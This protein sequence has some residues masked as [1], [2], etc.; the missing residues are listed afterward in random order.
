MGEG[1]KY[2]LGVGTG[3]WGLPK[4]GPNGR[5]P[6][7]ALGE[8]AVAFFRVSALQG[9]GIV[10]GEEAGLGGGVGCLSLFYLLPAQP[11]HPAKCSAAIQLSRASGPRETPGLHKKLMGW[12]RGR[13]ALPPPR[14]PLSPGI[15]R[16][17]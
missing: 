14:F 11:T 8:K 15:R 6:W 2:L 7:G 13:W 12:G 3:L 10:D 5:K 17:V 1:S 16:G 9:E 4:S